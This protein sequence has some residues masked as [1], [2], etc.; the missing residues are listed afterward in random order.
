MYTY[1]QLVWPKSRLRLDQKL[2]SL[3]LPPGLLEK[4]SQEL[5]L[6]PKWAAYI[7]PLALDSLAIFR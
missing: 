3:P 2:S 6:V 5:V 1:R 7:F 4:G